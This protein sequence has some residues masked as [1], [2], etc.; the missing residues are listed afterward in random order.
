MSPEGS[1]DTVQK[2]SALE[3]IARCG[4]RANDVAHRSPTPHFQP[5]GI[6]HQFVDR[7]EKFRPS[8]YCKIPCVSRRNP[9]Q[10]SE[11][12]LP[13]RHGCS[14]GSKGTVR[15]TTFFLRAKSSLPRIIREFSE[16]ERNGLRVKC[17]D[18]SHPKALHYSSGFV[19]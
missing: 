6:G 15:Q 8:Q 11:K 16:Q 2:P 18:S 13:N 17:L 5:P 12:T 4:V 10:L 7:T 19:S 14:A 1:G 9:L 3:F